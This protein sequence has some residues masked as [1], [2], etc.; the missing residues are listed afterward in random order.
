MLPLILRRAGRE[1]HCSSL[2]VFY[3]QITTTTTG[4]INYV[5]TPLGTYENLILKGKLI[6]DERQHDVVSALDNIQKCLDQKMNEQTN[7][8]NSIRGLYLHSSPGRGKT[9]LADM[10]DHKGITRMHFIEFMSKTH[11]FLH[12][13]RTT[14]HLTHMERISKVSKSL[15]P[16]PALYLDELEVTDI[17]DSSIL[18]SLIQDFVNIGKILIF[19]S[20]RSPENLYKGGLN[21]E[22]FQ[23]AFGI[24][25][26]EY[27]KVIH[28]DGSLD[29]RSVN[30]FVGSTTPFFTNDPSFSVWKQL[31]SPND[32]IEKNILIPVNNKISRTI[33]VPL[34][35]NRICLFQFSV[36]AG[37]N[38]RMSGQCYLAIARDLDVIMLSNIPVLKD[39]DDLRRLTLLIDVLYEKKKILICCVDT[40]TT[41]HDVFGFDIENEADHVDDQD[42]MQASSSSLMVLDEGGSSGRLTTMVSKDLEWSATGRAGASLVDLTS[43]R[44]SEVAFSRCKSRLQEMMRID[45]LEKA[46]VIEE[47]KSKVKEA[48]M[49]N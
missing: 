10:L 11:A 36:I 28:L 49:K 34:K 19:T 17:A 45:W 26:R 12:E 7:N 22:T 14:T 29:Y 24:A 40:V 5:N 2:F 30:S 1:S 27:C 41:F 44:F 3:R 31:L 15:V 33:N 47:T 32:I 42:C 35:S 21:V 6:R 23:P 4:S 39:R 25:V 16:T 43:G 20:N 9:M 18:K 37:I 48:L 46:D 13:L 8:N 38:S